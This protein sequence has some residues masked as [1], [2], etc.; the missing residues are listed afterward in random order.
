MK[1]IVDF[2][3]G[4]LKAIMAFLGT[5]VPLFF[6]FRVDGMTAGEWQ[7]LIVTSLAA[8]GLTFSIP[9]TGPF[10]PK[11]DTPPAEPPA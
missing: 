3:N 8:A 11:G 10:A 2:I 5:A 1:G 7:T 6:V 9:N 4:H